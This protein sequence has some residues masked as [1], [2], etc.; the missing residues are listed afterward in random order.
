HVAG[1]DRTR[2]RVRALADLDRRHEHRV[3]A[4][5]GVLPDLGAVLLL[6]VV[7]RGDVPGPDVGAGADLGVAHI[8]EVRHLGALA[9]LRVLHLDERADVRAGGEA[10]TGPQRH[11]RADGG[12]VADLRVA[13]D[14]LAD[15]RILPH[16]GVDELG[17][18]ADDR[19]PTDD[20]ATAE[21]RARE[22]L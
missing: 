1:D 12:A 21:H 18:G 20:G 11:V 7:V 2:T 19:A 22:Q 5:A 15:D 14:G 13:G 17:V 8:G 16:H 9:D 3:R 6:A 4:G 10:G